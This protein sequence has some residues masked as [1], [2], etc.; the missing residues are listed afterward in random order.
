MS[1]IKVMVDGVVKMDAEPG[2][3]RDNPPNLEELKLQAAENPTPWLQLVM[4]TIAQTAVKAMA[5]APQ[6]S[7]TITVTTRADG[8]DYSLTET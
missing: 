3:W 7:T 8:W 4:L 1:R 6:T 5:G 2:E